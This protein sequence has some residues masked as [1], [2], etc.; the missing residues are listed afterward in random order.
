MPVL[1]PDSI[2]TDLSALVTF[3]IIDITSKIYFNI[4]VQ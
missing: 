3:D 4:T 1:Y 2:S